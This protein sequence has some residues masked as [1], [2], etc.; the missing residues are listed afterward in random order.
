M[1]SNKSLFLGFGYVTL[2]LLPSDL[3]TISVSIQIL[4]QV[5]AGNAFT[6]V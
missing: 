2:I 5:E 4:P 3:I 6:A 1:E